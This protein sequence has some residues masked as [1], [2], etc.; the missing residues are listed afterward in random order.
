MKEYKEVVLARVRITAD[1]A[2]ELRRMVKI[3]A[4]STDRS[5]SEW[6]EEAVRHKLERE[7]QGYAGEQREPK[8]GAEKTVEDRNWIESDSSRLGE[9]EPYEWRADE[10]EEGKPLRFEP[11]VGIVVEGGK[12]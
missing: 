12:G 4:A 6:I 5:V 11:G 1:V 7:G 9:F 3:A 8:D 10:L 2:P